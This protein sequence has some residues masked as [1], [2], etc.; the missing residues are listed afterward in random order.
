MLIA[1]VLGG[2][3]RDLEEPNPVGDP[4][5]SLLDCN[6]G[7]TCGLLRSCVD[8]FC[9]DSPSIPQACVDAS[10]AQKKDDAS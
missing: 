8:G 6:P 2:C 1:F 5:S 9:E 3:P 7:A 4:C 10:Q